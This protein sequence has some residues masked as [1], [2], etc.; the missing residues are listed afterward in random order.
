MFRNN[1]HGNDA[2]FNRIVMYHKTYYKEKCV[3]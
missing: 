2:I 3:F 1:V